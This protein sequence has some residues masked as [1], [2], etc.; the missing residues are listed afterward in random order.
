MRAWWRVVWRHDVTTFVAPLA[1]D[2]PCIVESHKTI[3]HATY[4]KSGEVSQVRARARRAYLVFINQS[5]T[6][7]QAACS[8]SD[9]S[10]TPERGIR[11]I[12]TSRIGA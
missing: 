4:Y 7:T 3:D 5:L 10:G 2:M 8:L 9:G 1:V 12:F 6:L 11:S